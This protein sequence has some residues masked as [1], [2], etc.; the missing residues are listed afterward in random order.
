MLTVARL[1]LSVDCRGGSAGRVNEDLYRLTV[2]VLEEEQEQ[3]LMNQNRLWDNRTKG[4][5]REFDCTQQ[6][7]LVVLVV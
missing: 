1:Q 3:F 5:V 6:S 4:L 2:V 7:C